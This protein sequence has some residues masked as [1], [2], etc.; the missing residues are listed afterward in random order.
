[1]CSTEACEP[2]VETEEMASAF[3]LDREPAVTAAD[4]REGAWLCVSPEESAR[5]DHVVP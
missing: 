4:G 3:D 1:M 2:T 5:T